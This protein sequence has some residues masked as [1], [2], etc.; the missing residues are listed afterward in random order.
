ME[1]SLI[2]QI[3]FKE[4]FLNE[5]SLSFAKGILII[6]K[7]LFPELAVVKS[8][9]EK[10]RGTLVRNIEI[11]IQTVNGVRCKELGVSF[12]AGI[13]SLMKM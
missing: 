1:I 6:E 8:N 3:G 11:S 12:K 7:Y 13:D 10:T 2:D 5:D 4:S 9:A